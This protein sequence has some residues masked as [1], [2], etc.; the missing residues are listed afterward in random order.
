[1]AVREIDGASHNS[2]DNVRELIES[3]RSLPAPGSRY[4]IYI[5][6]EVHMLST[7]AFNA[8]LKSL[9]EPP[10]H[11][12]FILA[13]TEAHKIPETVISRC[14]RH[15]LRA[16][17]NQE[18][19]LCLRKIATQEKLQIAAEA[20]R[21][22]ARHADGSLRD[23]QSILD[24]VMAFC[25]GAVSAADVGKMLG[26]VERSVLF[27]L[28]QAIFQHDSAKALEVVNHAFDGGVDLGLF[29]REF[30][31]HFRE[32]MVARFGPADSLEKLGLS[33]DDVTELRRQVATIGAQDLQ[34]LVQLAREGADSALRSAYPKYALEALLVRMALRE[35][36]ADL[37]KLIRE[38]G[39]GSEAAQHLPEIKRYAAPARADTEGPIPALK[40]K[41]T[42]PQTMAGP[43]STVL[44]WGAF[45][46]TGNTDSSKILIEQLKRLKIE[47]F[48]A[49]EL[50][51]S[52]PDFSVK[53]LKS[54][55]NSK[56]LKEALFNF[57][58][59]KAWRIELR[60]LDAG[61][62]APEGSIAFQEQSDSVKHKELQKDS[63][64]NN[65]KFK[66]LQ[67]LFP[68]SKI[69]QIVGE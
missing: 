29:L 69:E 21:M 65:P 5:I 53:Y 42:E 50:L 41:Q 31:I 51:A 55:R 45:V 66:S 13:T 19:E 17:E 1:M 44:D 59:V 11:T 58:K 33:A 20:L 22:I 39:A 40:K 61:V 24:R 49:G 48:S 47:R 6:D 26:S 63:V 3:F 25:D 9:E 62:K 7:A 38:I 18:V 8:L 32:L 36:V 27:D 34:D 64:E 4:K 30:V 57:S 35:K 60:S 2:V 37:S 46:R 14:Q 56:Q 23:A 16:I 12:V 52:G 15:D 43:K 68:G 28:S 54:E 10:P 67:K